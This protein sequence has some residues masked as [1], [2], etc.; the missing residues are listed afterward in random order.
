MIPLLC[1]SEAK[2]HVCRDRTRESWREARLKHFRLEVINFDCPYGKEWGWRRTLSAQIGIPSPWQKIHLAKDLTPE[3]WPL[4][5]DSILRSLS[6]CSCRDK[7]ARTL[8]ALPPR[9]DDYFAWTVDFHNAINHELG[10]K[11]ISLEEAINI[12]RPDV[13]RS[14]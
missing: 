4:F 5:L 9:F 1:Q 10:K 14:A 7:T 13:P 8:E 12:W 2:C 6:F 3:S 11:E